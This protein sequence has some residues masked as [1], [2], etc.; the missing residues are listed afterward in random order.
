MEEEL[1]HGQLQT[2][3]PPSITNCSLEPPTLYRNKTRVARGLLPILV[4]PCL[5]RWLLVFCRRLRDVGA[6][7]ALSEIAVVEGGFCFEG[8]PDESDIREFQCS[9]HYTRSFFW[10]FVEVAIGCMEDVGELGNDIVWFFASWFYPDAD[11]MGCLS[12]LLRKL[13]WTM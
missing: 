7:A 10:S 6:C 9:V 1:K 8:S 2:M 13:Q 12:A 4:L 11:A 3:R 5:A